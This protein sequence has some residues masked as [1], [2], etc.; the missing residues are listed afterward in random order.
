MCGLIAFIIL[1]III[2][3]SSVFGVVTAACIIQQLNVQGNVA[4]VTIYVLSAMF[5][6]IPSGLIFQYFFM[7]R[8]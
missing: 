8:N 6:I 4:I 1:I 7:K 5:F 3:F 2:F